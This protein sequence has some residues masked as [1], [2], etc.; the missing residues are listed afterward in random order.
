MLGRS[1]ISN[2]V[3]PTKLPTKFELLPGQEGKASIVK[4]IEKTIDKPAI[5]SMIAT[6]A[7]KD[8]NEIVEAIVLKTKSKPY[9]TAFIVFRSE[10]YRKSIEKCLRGRGYDV[11]KFDSNYGYKVKKLTDIKHRFASVYISCVLGLSCKSASLS[12]F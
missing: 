10:Y 4:K 6:F 11:F 12:E 5:E 7:S 2:D 9:N 3:A 1:N 8:I